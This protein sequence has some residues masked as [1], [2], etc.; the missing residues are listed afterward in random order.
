MQML[1][2]RGSKIQ[3]INYLTGELTKDLLLKALKAL[4]VR[5]KEVLRTKEE[6]F[7]KLNLDPNNDEE[8]IHAILKHPKILVRPIV[9][10]GE[11]A[12]I[13]R[14]PENILKLF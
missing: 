9:I 13:G 2:E 14:P 12:V 8:V 7:Q 3:V 10:Q 4:N 1:E 6:E 11:R 5:P